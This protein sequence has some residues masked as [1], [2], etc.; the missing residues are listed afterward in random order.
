MPYKYKSIGKRRFMAGTGVRFLPDGRV[1]CQAVR[2]SVSKRLKRENPEIKTKDLFPEYQCR[3]PARNGYYV[4]RWHGAGW[5][6][7]PGPGRQ[8]K[9][10]RKKTDYIKDDLAD[11]YRTFSED[12]ELF[13]MR[14]T[15]SLMQ[16]RNAELLEDLAEGSLSH[17][18]KIDSLR[19]GLLLA[20]GGDTEGFKIIESVIDSLDNERLAW[21]EIRKNSTVFKDVTN[22]E[23]NRVKEMRLALNSEQ[24]FSL[25]ERLADL[26][27]KAVTEQVDLPQPTQQKLLSI[28]SGG[29][30]DIIGTGSRTLLESS[31][32]S[33]R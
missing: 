17:P 33:K 12:P 16:A 8:D 21:E 15:A 28:I 4:C 27:V 29:V 30:H 22:A 11:K 1:R 5:D 7:G 26:M 25:I 19:R 20:K 2:R 18:K 13:N 6:G 10:A 23:I 9:L 32:D 3:L 31:N 24:V 14:H